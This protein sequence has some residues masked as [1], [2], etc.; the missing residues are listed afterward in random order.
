MGRSLLKS[1]RAIAEVPS[2]H[3][4]QVP[5][6]K[7]G[8]V[9]ASEQLKNTKLATFSTCDFTGIYGTLPL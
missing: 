5:G 9:S 4:K 6:K 2:K 7:I 3:L 8:S 1:T